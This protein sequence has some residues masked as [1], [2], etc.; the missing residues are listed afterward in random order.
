MIYRFLYLEIVYIIVM[1][2]F[3]LYLY[4]RITNKF[5]TGNLP[6]TLATVHIYIYLDIIY[7]VLFYDQLSSLH[8]S[9]HIEIRRGVWQSSQCDLS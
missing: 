1:Y 9:K 4:N 7:L 5:N 6:K 2:S 8:C 3:Y